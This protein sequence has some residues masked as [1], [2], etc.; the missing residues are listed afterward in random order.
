VIRGYKVELDLNN[1]QRTLCAKH[2]GTARFAYNW[3]LSRKIEEFKAGR[4]NPTAIDLHKELN[5]LKKT[6]LSWM[7][8]V[9][10]CAPQEALRNLDKA[11][12]NFFHRV[13]LKKTGNFTG[14]V[15]FPKFKSKKLGKGSF[16]LT[17]SISVKKDKIKL[18]RLGWLRLKEKGYIPTEGVKILKVTVSEKAGH[19]FVSAQVEQESEKILSSAFKDT[20][21]EKATGAPIGV[22]LGIKSMAVC[23]DL[24][25]FENPKTLYKKL[26]KLRR[27]QRELSR[28]KKGGKNREKSRR[29]VAM[30]H[31]R[32]ANIRKDAIH[33]ATSS[34]VAKT[35]PKEQRPSV[36]V[37]EDLNVS[38]LLK[39]HKLARAI[40]DSGFFEFRRQLTYKTALLGVSLLVADRFFPSSKLCSACG[41][42]N[43]KLTLSMREWTCDCGAHHERD[44]NAAINLSRLALNYSI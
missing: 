18:P 5:L 39:N 38:G 27:V 21:V 32:I 35:K 44:L 10:K 29:K 15:G 12:A 6:E 31:Y 40:S 22:D 16:Q 25:E 3:G 33:K 19:W 41:A 42:I 13:K 24:R 8:E 26:Q 1:K 36:I 2:A 9:S 14:K 11:Y 28:R 34:I 7:Y 17:G 43:D 4:K 37:I 23:S 20:P 30:L